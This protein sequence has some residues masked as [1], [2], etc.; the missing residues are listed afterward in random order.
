MSL[1]EAAIGK[2]KKI[3]E[4]GIHRAAQ[5]PHESPAAPRREQRTQPD[6]AAVAARVAQ[7]RAL[8][9]AAVD[10]QIMERHGVLLQVADAAAQRSYRI[11]RTRVQQRMQAQGWHSLAVT[12]AGVAEGK[13]V[14]AINLAISLARDI[15]TW[16]YLVDLDLQRPRVASYLGLQFDKGISDYLAGKAQFE[17]VV[18]SPGLDRL[19]IIPNSQPV[20]HSSD[21][22]GSPRIRE[23]CELLA[24]ERPRPIVIFDL[25]PVLLGDDVIKFAPNA[26]CTLFVVAEGQTARAT[27]KRASE[28]LH[29]MNLLGLVL[30]QST[31][32][33]DGGYY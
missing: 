27:L 29:G 26:D 25:P 23:L 4:T 11:L 1:I 21:V 17:E 3:A 28:A 13:T 14:T 9:V 12:A 31:E 19:A 16:V 5:L 20:E 2:A 18:Y 8:P 15:N 10:A 32:R 33:E 6:A 30:N 7:A 22:L 24:A